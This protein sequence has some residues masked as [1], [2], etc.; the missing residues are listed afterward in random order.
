MLPQTWKNKDVMS[1]K[2]RALFGP[3]GCLALF[4][5]VVATAA[6]DYGIMYLNTNQQAQWQA[7]LA[8][9]PVYQLPPG[10]ANSPGSVNLLSHLHDDPT[11]R[12]QGDTGTCWLWGC[13]AVM[14]IDY[15]VQHGGAPA[16]TNGLSV[17]F[18]AA[19][20]GFVNSSLQSGGS[21]NTFKNFYEAVGFALPWTNAI[22]TD[23][24]G[25]NKTPSAWIT[26]QPNCPLSQVTLTRLNTQ[27]NDQQL[28]IATIKS[29]LD[30]SKALFFELLLPSLA[31]WA[32]FMAYWGK[33]NLTEDAIIDLAPWAQNPSDGTCGSHLMACVGYNDTDPDPANHYWII[34]NSWG[35]VDGLRPNAAFHLA[36]NTQYDASVTNGMPVPMFKFGTIDTAWS[37]KVLKGV[38]SLA[39]NLQNT[40]PGANTIQ[41][42]GVSFPPSVAPTNVYSASLTF[43]NYTDSLNFNNQ[44]I[45]CDPA[46]GTWTQ[47]TNGFHYLS[48]AGV[49]PSLQ[50]DIN[51]LT[52]TW[53]FMANNLDGGLNRYIDSH[54]G[55]AF[56]LTYLPT[57][58]GTETD[59]GLHAFVYD[60][61]LNGGS[62]QY[63][64]PPPDSPALSFRLSG[65]QGVLCIF[66][67]VGRTCEVLETWALGSPWY[68]RT[69]VP[70]TLPVQQVNLPAPAGTNR[71]WRVKVQ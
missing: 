34:L 63:T 44:V 8:A 53:S 26:T 49:V 71:F 43:P 50:L 1:F 14:S 47:D 24:S 9:M 52:C 55:I 59:L 11:T 70:M 40:S 54:Y 56:D 3:V 67:E 29:A 37:G 5:P 28:A 18:A 25:C 4:L 23:G 6:L 46:N 21:P 32:N 42:S 58:G 20:L 27:T 7:A 68:L 66:G 13:T 65:G 60:E 61:L 12:D 62:S 2:T 10:Y 33:S 51:P 36:M 57:Y 15:D 39:V 31:D 16:L 64:S 19:N 38:A 41:I 45:S 17:E 48:N 69:T 22:W 30:A 35:T